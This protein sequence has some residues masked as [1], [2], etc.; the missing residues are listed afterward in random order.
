MLENLFVAVLILTGIGWLAL[1][2]FPRQS[3]SSFW[4]AGVVLPVV[5]CLLYSVIF[6]VYW[7]QEPK[8]EVTGFLSLT[9]LR[10][11]FRNSGLLLSAFVDL[12]VLPLILGAWMARKAVQIRMPYIWLLPC[13][14]LTPAVPATGFLVFA[15]IVT[16]RGSWGELLKADSAGAY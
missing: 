11:L 8:G 7:F 10:S 12:T 6:G 1:I 5:L 15:V 4:L 13:L 14:L 3:W 16:V 2:L 9:G